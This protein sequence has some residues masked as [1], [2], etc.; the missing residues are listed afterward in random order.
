MKVELIL[1]IV[2][3]VSTVIYT[4]INALMLLESKKSRNQR[5]TPLIIA[6]LQLSENREMIKLY[7]ENVGEGYAKDVTFNFIKNHNLFDKDPVSEMY[8]F[9]KNGISSFPSGNKMQCILD[10][11]RNIDF[12]LN[13][14]IEI[15]IDYRDLR[16]KTYKDNYKLLF[17]QIQE[18]YSEIPDT[19]IG[20]IPYQLKQINKTLTKK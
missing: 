11:P 13:P 19:Y 18:I 4:S 17:S 8:G 5:I 7:I 2:L 1:S 3:A 16:N 20:Q 10:T 6:H 12:T 15:E 9:L 14:Y